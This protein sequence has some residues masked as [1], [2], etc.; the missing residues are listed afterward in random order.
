MNFSPI[1]RIW[2]KTMTSWLPK[3]FLAAKKN[4]PAFFYLTPW[5]MNGWNT[6]K[7][8]VGKMIV[9]FNWVIFRFHPIGSMGLVYFHTF[10]IKNQPNVGKYTI[11]GSYWH[12]NLPGAVT[13][14]TIHPPWVELHHHGANLGC[15]RW[16][17]IFLPAKQQDSKK[18]RPER[19]LQKSWLVGGFNPSEK[20]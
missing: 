10:T 20:Y 15:R 19:R 4:P 11:H 16:C 2:K 3:F 14:E 7:F 12:V 1:R 6:T 17:P 9:L 18:A 13:V 8:Q 5:K